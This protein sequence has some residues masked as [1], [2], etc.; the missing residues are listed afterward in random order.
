VS[1]RL[2]GAEA[3]VVNPFDLKT[4]VLAKHPQHIVFVFACTR[5]K[6]VTLKYQHGRSS[7]GVD[8]H[9]STG[10]GCGTGGDHTGKSGGIGKS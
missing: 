6:R 3:E 8:R 9:R 10:F 7:I 4:I 5:L 1:E 2:S